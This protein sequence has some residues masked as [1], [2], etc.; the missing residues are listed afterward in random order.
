MQQL[1]TVQQQWTDAAE[2]GYRKWKQTARIIRNTDEQAKDALNSELKT[3]WIRISNNMDILRWGY[4]PRGTFSTKE[5]YKIISNDPAPKD[6]LWSR[7]WS[8][9]VWPKVSLFLWLF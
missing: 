9:G 7:L 5:A 2:Q 3:R 4:T 6:P 1:E 8:L